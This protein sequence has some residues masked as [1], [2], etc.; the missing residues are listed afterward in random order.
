MEGVVEPLPKANVR[1]SVICS[2]GRSAALKLMGMR[3]PRRLRTTTRCL[4]MR[5]RTR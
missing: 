2:A 4:Q 1:L 5:R 3:L